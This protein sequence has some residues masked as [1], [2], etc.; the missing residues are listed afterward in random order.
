MPAR[1]DVAAIREA[2]R[3][4]PARLACRLLGHPTQ[5][6]GDEWRWGSKGSLSVCV[7]GQRAGLWHSFEEQRGGD[8]IT[9]TQ[10]LLGLRFDATL[11]FIARTYNLPPDEITPEA[12]P[13]LSPPAPPPPPPPP[14]NNDDTHEGKVQAARRLW[15]EA[16]PIEGTPAET[17]LAARAL[18]LAL[19]KETLD[20]RVLRF[21]PHC[22]RGKTDRAP[23]LLALITDPEKNVPCGVQRTFL[24]P[25]G[26]DRVRTGAGRMTLGRPGVVRLS[27]D[28]ETARG[29]HLAEGVETA[30]ACGAVFGLLPVWATLGTSGLRTF[31]ILLGLE[32]L[33]VC[34]DADEAGLDSAY[35]CAERYLAAGFVNLRVIAPPQGDWNDAARRVAGER[36]DERK[37]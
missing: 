33:T 14:E 22:P 34:A 24:Q 21:H 2:T 17:Y 3:R 31:P 9:L 30:I 6:H 35:A 11:E 19:I 27:R 29:L 4:D 10:H 15:H 23:A 26:R 37:R 20:L 36:A 8:L 16:A 25:D 1:W 5:R 18:P 13:T 28:E 32:S 7:R 12:W